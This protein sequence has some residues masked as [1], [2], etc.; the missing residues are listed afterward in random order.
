MNGSDPMYFSYPEM[1]RTHNDRW[2]PP[3]PF[4]MAEDKPTDEP[5]EGEDEA[6]G[7]DDF[8]GYLPFQNAPIAQAK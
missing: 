4:L 3:P 5:D 7:D 6:Q 1:Y 8:H 2:S